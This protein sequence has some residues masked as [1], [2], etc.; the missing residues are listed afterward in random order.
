[1]KSRIQRLS[2]FILSLLM[3]CAFSCAAWASDGYE[4]NQMGKKTAEPLVIPGEYEITVSVPGA[5][6]SDEYA[7][8]I[9][10]AD[11]SSSM[12]G[13]YEKMKSMI[14][15]LGSAIL[16]DD[17]TMRLTLM[18]FGM[19]PRTAVTFTAPSQVN[20]SAFANLAFTS[21]RQGVSATNCEASLNHVY[22]YISNASKLRS[23]YVVY[24]SDGNCNMDET[25]ADYTTWDE[26]P[27]WFASGMTVSDII[28]RYA[29]A[30]CDLLIA[31]KA[32][33]AP[34]AAL[35][36]DEC[37]AIESARVQYG[38]SSA[39]YKAAVDAL[40]AAIT[41]EEAAGI[42][43]VD[44]VLADVL[45]SKV[46]GCSTAQAEK[47][48]LS[49]ADKYADDN[50]PYCLYYMIHRMNVSHYPDDYTVR[51]GDVS[52]NGRPVTWGARAAAAADRLAD[53][54]KV[55]ELYMMD[56]SGNGTSWMKAGSRT[57]TVTSSNI[58]YNQ[59]RDIS[60]AI[61]EI[62]SLSTEFFTTVY[63]D[64]TVVDPMSK[65]V[66]LVPDSIRI[67]KDDTLVWQNG[68]WLIDNPP[69]ANPITLTGDAAS[70]YTITWKIKDGPLLYT[71]RYFLKYHV[72]VDETVDGFEYGASYPAN[73]PTHVEY[74]DENGTD[75]SVEVEVPNVSEDKP[76]QFGEGD[77]G[78][79]LYK[80]TS[81][82]KPISGIQF[83]IYRVNPAEGETTSPTPTQEEIDLYKT[84][85]N[86]VTTITTNANG[87]ASVNMGEDA[88][89]YLLVEHDSSKVRT[90]VDPFYVRLP[91]PDP[92]TGV[93]TN[94]ISVY[95]KNEP[96]P[97][98]P[99]PD[100]PII[101]EDGEDEETEGRF[102]IVKHTEGDE[103]AVLAGA[104]F[105]IYQPAAQSD[106]GAVE[107]TYNGTTVWG[108]P[109][110]AATLVTGENGAAE[111]GLLPFGMY[112]LVET[113]APDG[114]EL[115]ADVV[116]VFVTAASHEDANA[117]YIANVA[118]IQLP[119]TGSTGTLAFTLSGILLCSLSIVLLLRRRAACRS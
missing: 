43:Y 27:E 17:G 118:G 108:V 36:Y 47:L 55:H 30:Q 46:T 20:S 107:L 68:S 18:G 28:S 72:S 19:G 91:M 82:K 101:P 54:P 57:N 56:F 90:P 11:A 69:T 12:S 33:L 58:T 4:F 95:P 59:T 105:V 3:L 45:G 119:E 39:E 67:Y 24:L 13:H 9:I 87:Y 41:A 16:H 26:H 66:D 100:D 76:E 92:I 31:G 74:T 52:E 117:L 25:P 97:D 86:L 78:I 35:Y 84:D 75:R 51:T 94:V 44:A 93:V 22:D 98:T 10:M 71:D 6:A 77:Y 42:R 29:G 65:W 114:H 38:L 61:T 23:T 111:S 106:E 34:T 99:A 50:F 96:V 15:E 64:V 102:K 80:S 89:L 62:Q 85:A 81:D 48:F 110:N 8:V 63:A 88:G 2:V 49:Y 103:T 40:Y 1:M 14:R 37:F 115:L 5:V 53:H 104:E 83:S 60:T 32:P 109:A 73:D 79:R 113:K 7:E 112:Y 21:L 70:G 116:P